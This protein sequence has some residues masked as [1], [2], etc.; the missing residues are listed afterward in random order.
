MD[1]RRQSSVSL[2]LAD[3]LCLRKIPSPHKWGTEW[4]G[5]CTTLEVLNTTRICSGF[6]D[7]L[8]ILRHSQFYE[9]RSSTSFR[10]SLTEFSIVLKSTTTFQVS[11]PTVNRFELGLRVL[12]LLIKRKKGEAK[13]STV[14]VGSDRGV[15]QCSV[16]GQ[17]PLTH[18][19][20]STGRPLSPKRKRVGT[21]HSRS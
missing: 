16:N 1:S 4:K 7:D 6:R 13:G 21:S 20:G 2:R 15:Q 18:E 12:L 11:V 17:P 10:F 5:L 9:N 19:R 8:S 14:D 3:S